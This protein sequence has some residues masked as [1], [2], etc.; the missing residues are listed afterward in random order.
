VGRRSLGI[1]FALAFVAAA[2]SGSGG[3]AEVDAGSVADAGT[4]S[5]GPVSSGDAQ[6]PSE[7]DVDPQGDTATPG[8][9][10][11]GELTASYRGVTEETIKVGVAT[12]D[13]AGLQEFGVDIEGIDPAIWAPAFAQAFNERG[14][15]HGR[16]M[17]IVIGI[18]LPVGST[19]SDRVCTELTQDQEVFVV[20]GAM[21]GDNPLC[22][23][24]LNE[25]PYVGMF[26]LTADRLERSAA[27]F[28]ASEMAADAQRTNALKALIGQ[29]TFDGVK[30]GVYWEEADENLATEIV[31]PLLASAGVDVVET[32]AQ[33]DYGDDTAAASS[34]ADTLFAA[35]EGSGA[36]MYLNISGLVQFNRAVDRN[37]PE[38]PFVL[39]N[40]Q[41]TS[42][43][44]ISTSG[45]DPDVLADAIGVTAAKPTPDEWRADPGWQQCLDEINS[46]GLGSFSA[47]EMSDGLV[48]SLGQSCQA[49]RLLEHLLT[50]ADPVL[51]PDALLAAA[52]ATGELLLPGMTAGSLGPGKYSVGDEVRYYTYD[53][54]QQIMVPEGD[55]IVV[56][57]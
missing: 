1:L 41:M 11:P 28:F 46:S 30:L 36:D 29:G 3:D 8:V 38:V 40:G 21:L 44:I 15:A 34:A 43:A 27:P 48:A 56:A 26:G 13:F 9:E 42:G 16:T 37:R 31:L 55:P 14:G 53:P 51:T 25:T 7:S 4:D 47:D 22:V 2:C 18:F 45:Y 20:L 52:D 33:L 50:A 57:G 32:V 35:L 39:L 54:D 17:E 23:T 5:T 24:R 10:T 6:D 19:E 12:I 49:F